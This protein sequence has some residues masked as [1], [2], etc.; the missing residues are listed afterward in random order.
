M[1]RRAVGFLLREQDRFGLW[2][3]WPRRHPQRIAIPP[4]LDDTSC[5]SLALMAAGEEAPRNARFLL[6]NRNRDGLF[7][8]WILP[9]RAIHVPLAPGQLARAPFLYRFFRATSAEPND[10]DAVVNANALFYLG[11]FPGAETVAAFLTQVLA[12][13]REQ[14]C[15]KWYDNPFAI[16]YFFSRAL[17]RVVPGAVSLV[18]GRLSCHAPVNALERALAI[19]ALFSCNVCP[20]DTMIESLIAAQRADGSWLR[21]PLYHGGRKRSGHGVLAAPDPHTPHWGSEALTTGFCI[22]ALARWLGSAARLMGR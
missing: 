15:D 17:E 9:R 1:R 5:A 21:E 13:G 14:Q 4:D 11:T 18:A 8:T 12:E 10:V 20:P 2:R 6:A 19:C 3:H 22:E 16:W 7:L